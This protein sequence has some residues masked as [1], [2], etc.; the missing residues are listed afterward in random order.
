MFANKCFLWKVLFWTLVHAKVV[1]LRFKMIRTYTANL[2]FD[3]LVEPIRL[4][5]LSGPVDQIWN[6]DIREQQTKICEIRSRGS[7]R[8]HSSHI[9]VQFWYNLKSQW[10]IHLQKLEIHEC[11][12]LMNILLICFI[13]FHCIFEF[14]K[15][16][17]TLNES[18]QYATILC[19]FYLITESLI[20]H[21]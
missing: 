5:L 11:F 20:H 9:P 6:Y 14:S 2:K 19:F 1:D 3:S 12:C 21:I 16:F 8:T 15:T 18:H 13:E 4:W 10:F 7:T 17:R